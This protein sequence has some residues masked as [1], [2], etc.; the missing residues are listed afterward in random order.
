MKVFLFILFISYI[1]GLFTNEDE[2]IQKK[3]RVSNKLK[4][5]NYD[6]D[7]LDPE[8]WFYLKEK[9]YEKYGRK[10]IKCESTIGID[11]HHKIPISKG[12][13][14][15]LENLVPLCRSCHEQLHGFKFENG[16]INEDRKKYGKETPTTKIGSKEHIICDAIENNYRIKIRYKSGKADNYKVTERIIRPISLELGAESSNSYV[17]GS[18][19]DINKT[20]LKAFCELRNA[21]RLFRLD[22]IEKIIEVIK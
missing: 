11:V 7:K 19:Y 21:E 1:L 6:L 16:N 8:S 4:P 3:R 17:K 13:T 22:R 10:C 20:F 5:N 9:V 15:T 2:N 12:G 18:C 14:N